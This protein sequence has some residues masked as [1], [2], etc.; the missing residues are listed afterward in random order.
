MM[1]VAV[2]YEFGT[3]RES[4]STEDQAMAVMYYSITARF[5]VFSTTTTRVA[6]ILYT[7]AFFSDVRLIK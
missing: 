2:S 4:V 6:F 1:S 3:P 7:V 5:R